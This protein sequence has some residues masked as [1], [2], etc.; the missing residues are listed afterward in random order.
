MPSI[1][2]DKEVE[3]KLGAVATGPAAAAR[4]GAETLGRG[5]NAMDAAAATALACAVLEPESVD[6]GGYIF[7][8]VVCEAVS[9]KFWSVDGNAAAPRAAHEH[10][11]AILPMNPGQTGINESEYDCS[12][13]GD[14]NI[15]GPLSV[16]VPGFLGGVGKLW[17]RWGQLTWPEIVA[18]SQQLVDE[19]FHYGP[20]AAA[21]QRRYD[22]IRHFKPILEHLMPQGRLPSR[23]DVWHRPGLETTLASLSKHGWREFYSGELGRRIAGYVQQIGGILTAEDMKNYAAQIVPAY[24]ISYRG[25]KVF[26]SRLPTGALTTLEVLNMLECFPPSPAD[27]PAASWHHLAEILKLAWQDRIRYLGDP[28][29][30]DVP[31]ER[32]L[33]KSY[34]QGRTEHLRQFPKSVCTLDPFALPSPRCT[35]HV[36]AADAEGNVVSATISQGLPF[37]SCVAVPGTGVT[38]SHGMSRL[39]PRPGLPNSIA[40]HKRPLSNVSPLIVS[41]PDRIVALGTRGGRSIVSVCA[42]LARR[43]LDG[44]AGLSE[45][46]LAPR[47]HVCAREPLEFLEFEFTEKVAQDILDEV[48]AMGHRVERKR[49]LVEGAGAAHCAEFLHATRTVRASGNTWAAGVE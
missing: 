1:L 43:F 2:E 46:L 15:N 22:I 41:L 19:G 25:H 12:V 34:A 49:E 48:A 32:L 5:G 40:G 33:D 11:F 4:I 47:L 23:D 26:G 31:V 44:S 6:F 28:D 8:A 38:L 17:D 16:A 29:F 13:E 37:G 7:S 3:S 21:I 24:E 10:M 20:T 36:S 45:A 18:P 9:G 30:A 35:V 39:D 14:A 42:Q 27:K